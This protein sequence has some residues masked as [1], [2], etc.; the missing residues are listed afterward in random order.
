M[1]KSVHSMIYQIC[2]VDAKCSQ[3]H[4]ISEKYKQYN[5]YISFKIVP[6]CN[7]THLRVTVKVSE[8]FLEAIW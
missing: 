3:N 8:T 5:H 4:F 2:M 7:P 6:L 1:K